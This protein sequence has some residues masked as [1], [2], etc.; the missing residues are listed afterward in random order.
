MNHHHYILLPILI[1]AV[2]LAGCVSSSSS[3]PD[4]DT[5]FQTSTIDA[6]LEGVYDGDVSF[7]DLRTHG[8][9]GLGTV[10]ALDGEMI[11]L[12][13]SAYHVRTDGVAYAIPD[14]ALTPFAAVTV[15]E[16]DLVGELSAG[17]TM[18][19]AE[20]HIEALLPSRNIMYAIRIDGTFSAMKTR[21]VPAQVHPYPP[22]LA[23]VADQ[24]VFEMGETAGTIVGFWMPYYVSGINVPSFHLHYLTE[25]RTAGGHVLDFT[26][27]SAT[28]GLDET[29][30]LDID[31]IE[32]EAY[33]DAPLDEESGSGLDHVEKK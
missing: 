23:V 22:L 24:A 33:L 15:Y 2:L 6:L 11:L 26:V 32:T 14:D 10:Q 4:T 9:F 30:N 29:Y 25:D 20:A 8:D 18:A 31:L 21:S 7:G 28:V 13:G 17:M 16:A 5:L 1:G 27:A 3:Q 12:D 19:D